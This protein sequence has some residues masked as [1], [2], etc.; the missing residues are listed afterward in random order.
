MLNH[1][2]LQGRL[3]KDPEMRTTGNGTAVTSFTLAVERDFADK[4]TGDRLCDFIDCV[5]WRGAA[6]FIARNFRRGQMAVVSGRLEIR[7]YTDKEG[8]TK[9]ATEINVRDVYFCGEKKSADE[10]QV[11]PWDA[12]D[13]YSQIDVNDAE[14]PFN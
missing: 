9:R 3:T 7:R 13:P 10:N 6:E 8:N 2:E 12:N 14:L 4:D 5:A 11:P 1:I